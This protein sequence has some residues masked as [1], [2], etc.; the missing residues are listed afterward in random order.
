MAPRVTD[1]GKETSKG[2]ARPKPPAG[3]DGKRHRRRTATGTACAGPTGKMQTEPR[4]T[5]YV[6]RRSSLARQG[7]QHSSSYQTQ[8]D[9]KSIRKPTAFKF[10]ASHM[11]YNIFH[12]ETFSSIQTSVAL[13]IRFSYVLINAVS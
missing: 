13:Q 9:N 10:K 3:Q 8:D 6:M 4:L 7:Q 5:P 11:K 1:R 2:L 12:F